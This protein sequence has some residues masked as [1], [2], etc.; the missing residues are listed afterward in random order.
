VSKVGNEPFCRQW[1]QNPVTRELL[2][3]FRLHYIHIGPFVN[4]YI[5]D[6]KS[7]LEQDKTYEYLTWDRLEYVVHIGFSKL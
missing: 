7:I 4:A 1:N 6:S 3:H 2:V 5:S